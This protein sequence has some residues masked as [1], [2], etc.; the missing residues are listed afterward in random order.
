[1]EL[2]SWKEKVKQFFEPHDKKN[3]NKNHKSQK[4]ISLPRMNEMKND[5]IS[6]DGTIMLFSTNSSYV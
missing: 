6:K 2:T 5:D 3:K 4:L 1:M